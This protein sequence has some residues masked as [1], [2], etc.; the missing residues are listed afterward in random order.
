MSIEDDLLAEE[1]RRRGLSVTQLKMQRATPAS[2]MREII[3]DGRRST[4]RSSIIASKDAPAP[5]PTGNGWI[6]PTPLAQPPG[7][8]ILD[9]M[10]DAQ[11]AMDRAE[12]KFK[13]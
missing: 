6:E 5:R 4:E 1:A 9:H 2:L 10:M 12:R 8:A 7:I 11:D 13:R 3:A